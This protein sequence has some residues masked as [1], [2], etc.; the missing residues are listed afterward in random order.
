MVEGGRR[1]LSNLVHSQVALHRTFGGVVP[2]VAA[3]DH[4]E[5]L[6]GLVTI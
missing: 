6:P 3:R 2:E 1:L 4:L 5:K